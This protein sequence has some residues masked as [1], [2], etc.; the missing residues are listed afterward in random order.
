MLQLGLTNPFGNIQDEIRDISKAYDEALRRGDKDS[1]YA[2]SLQRRGAYLRELAQ[3]EALSR[4]TGD[5][6]D[7][8]SRRMEAQ[9]RAAK[10]QAKRDA[11]A[12]AEDKKTS[13]TSDEAAR[14]IERQALAVQKLTLSEED[15]AVAEVFLAGA[16]I[17]Q[18]EA[19]QRLA[20]ALS[21]QNKAQRELK[22]QVDS[23]L[24]LY[25]EYK[26]LYEDTATPAQKLADEEARLL[27]LRER[28]IAN[29][30]EAAAVERMIA[31]ARM[32]AVDR[33]FPTQTKD[34]LIELKDLSKELGLAISTAFEDAVIRGEGLRDLLRSLEQDIIRILMRKLVTQPLEGVI[35][36]FGKQLLPTIFGARE[37]GGP[38]AARRAYLVGEKG[39]ELF[40]PNQ[41]GYITSNKDAQSMGR[42]ITV[43][44]HFVVSG[45]VDRRSQTQIAAA[46]GQGLQRAV[47][48]NT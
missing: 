20:D 37:L 3:V 13:A 10:A 29:G 7:Q 11:P 21:T 42:Q 14:L 1:L 39:P 28:L 36:D 47:G 6:S 30:Y 17:Q 32:N 15:L 8:I 26:K 35:T 12:L 9:A 24:E 41:A 33:L 2:Q 44:N 4:A 22:E 19:S 40:M 43:T 38:V 31:E 45:P 5:F 23:A 27:E 46:V 48:R 16:T 34:Q 25:A 18:L